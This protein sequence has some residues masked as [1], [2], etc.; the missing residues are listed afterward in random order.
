[1]MSITGLD[2]PDDLGPEGERACLAGEDPCILPT[3]QHPG[4]NPRVRTP[5]NRDSVRRTSE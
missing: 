2:I 4:R 5:T 3:P 1:M